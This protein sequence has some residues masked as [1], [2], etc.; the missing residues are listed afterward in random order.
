M[1]VIC[2][3]L[4][5]VRLVPATHKLLVRTNKLLHYVGHH[6]WHQVHHAV[7]VAA[8]SSQTV[9][10]YACRVSP[11]ALAAIALAVIP[12]ASQASA[13]GGLFSPSGQ[14]VAQAPQGSAGQVGEIGRGGSLP[15]SSATE[16]PQDNLGSTVITMAWTDVPSPASATN[17]TPAYPAGPAFIMPVD[18]SPAPTGQAQS[19]PEPSSLAVLAAALCCVGLIKRRFRYDT[20][21]LPVCSRIRM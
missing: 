4:P 13:P 16:K 19:V 1:V 10:Q 6:V 5:F 15:F 14:I 21:V 12:P 17:I 9:I 2:S 18:N 20:S 8:T 3:A 7:H 11:G